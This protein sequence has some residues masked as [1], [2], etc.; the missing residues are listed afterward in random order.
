[1]IRDW[2]PLGVARTASPSMAGT[3]LVLTAILVAGFIVFAWV[4]TGRIE[5]ARKE[6]AVQCAPCPAGKAGR[7]C[8]GYVEKFR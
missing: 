3:L 5:E 6:G 7:G 1:M 2:T 8:Q 4:E